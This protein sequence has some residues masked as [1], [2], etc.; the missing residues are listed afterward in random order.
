M[1]SVFSRK[2][3]NGNSKAISFG[4]RQQTKSKKNLLSA[5]PADLAA[6]LL[7]TIARSPGCSS[8]LSAAADKGYCALHIFWFDTLIRQRCGSD[9]NEPERQ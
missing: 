9:T 4:G 2:H 7:G 8:L 1:Q 5:K 3:R 6:E